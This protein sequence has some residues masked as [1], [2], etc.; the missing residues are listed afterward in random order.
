MRRRA[1]THQRRPRSGRP[2]RRGP[3]LTRA[4]TPRRAHAATCAQ[5]SPSRIGGA[6]ASPPPSKTPRA[7]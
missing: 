3:T 7:S 6:P 1:R 4:A 5:P 2:S